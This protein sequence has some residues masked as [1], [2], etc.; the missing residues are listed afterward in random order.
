MCQSDGDETQASD[1]DDDMFFDGPKDSSFVFSVTVT[2]GTPS[3]RE[4]S[5]TG[6]LKKKY[7]SRGSGVVVADD[8]GTSMSMGMEGTTGASESLGG[9][10]RAD[11]LNVVPFRKKMLRMRNCQSASPRRSWT[12][13][14]VTHNL[15]P[16][17][18]IATST[19]PMI[20]NRVWMT[21]TWKDGKMLNLMIQRVKMK[22]GMRT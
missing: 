21:V 18:G 10:L 1:D 22:R 12:R 15:K 7:K 8:E 4:Q 19:T 6:D 16:R 2:E 20:L 9:L 13:T 3:P 14:M 5:G 17:M 11:Y